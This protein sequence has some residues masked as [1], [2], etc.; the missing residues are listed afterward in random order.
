MFGILKSRQ[1][2]KPDF[3]SLAN[4]SLFHVPISNTTFSSFKRKSKFGL[5][6]TTDFFLRVQTLTLLFLQYVLLHTKV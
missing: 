1:I 5:T 3:G 6:V 2:F 4:Y